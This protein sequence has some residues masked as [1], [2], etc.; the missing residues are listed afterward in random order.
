MMALKIDAKRRLLWATEVALEGFSWSPKEDWGRS[1]ILLFDLRTGKL[2]WRVE[3][4]SHT[5]FGDM[6][7]TA[8]GDAIVSDGDHGGIYRIRRA[9]RQIER[10]DAGDFI[11]PQT[12]VV[13]PGDEHLLV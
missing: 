3:G 11:S 13:L 8:A 7:L 2:L 4:P 5:A 1:A 9:T 10:L 12:P 6:T